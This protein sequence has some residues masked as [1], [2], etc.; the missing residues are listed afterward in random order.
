MMAQPQKKDA[1]EESVPMRIICCI[2]AVI[3]I[4]C[5]FIFGKA[6]VPVVDFGAMDLAINLLSIWLCIGGCM[7][8]YHYRHNFPPQ[9]ER[10]LKIA[11][12]CIL[13][14]LARELW[15]A[16][17]HS[18]Q[19]ECLYPLVNAL[20]ASSIVS[21][22]ELRSRKDIIATSAFGLTLMAL[23]GC[24]GRSI[25]FGGCV[26]LY[27]VLGGVLLCLC[28]RSYAM[29]L[30]GADVRVV[31]SSTR[32][33]YL[34][35]LVLSVLMLPCA[36]VAAFSFLPRA[37]SLADHIATQVRSFVTTFIYQH[38]VGVA[39]KD[40]GLA[41]ADP[42][43]KA[44]KRKPKAQSLNES[45]DKAREDEK[46]K[47]DAE[48]VRQEKAKAEK[49]KREAIQQ[50]AANDDK[51]KQDK[52]K[53][54]PEKV[55]ALPW[56][57]SLEQQKDEPKGNGTI[58]DGNPQIGP[59]GVKQ[60]IKPPLP[61]VPPPAKKNSAV[62]S[63]TGENVPPPQAKSPAAASGSGTV[64]PPDVAAPPLQEK[65]ALKNPKSKN[66]AGS[67]KTK[68]GKS[69]TASSAIPALG[70]PENPAPMPGLQK[71]DVPPPEGK[72]SSDKG[73]KSGG[74]QPAKTPQPNANAPKDGKSAPANT[75]PPPPDGQAPAAAPPASS[76]APKPP[77][78]TNAP[79]SMTGVTADSS[80][81]L[82]RPLAKSDRPLFSLACNRRVYVKLMCLDSF[83]GRA[84]H[85]TDAAETWGMPPTERGVDLKSCPFL[86]VSQALPVMELTENFEL[87]SD[88]GEFVPTAGVAKHLSLLSSVQVDR[89]GNIMADPSLKPGA[90]YTAICD[91]PSV[92]LPQMR[93]T[94][95]FAD[96]E[97][98]YLARYLILPENQSDDVVNLSDELCR[99]GVN[100]FT[101]AES[102]VAYL[103]KNYKYTDD[104][105]SGAE[106]SNLADE[107]LFRKK[108]GD[109]KAFATAFVVLCRSAGIPSRLVTGFL[110]GDPDPVSG[111]TTVKVKHAHAW[112]EIY[113]EPYG[114]VSFDPT[115]GGLL[116]ARAEQ[117]YY[118]YAEVKRDL[119]ENANTSAGQIFSKVE[120]GLQYAGYLIL[121]LAAGGAVFALYFIIRTLRDILREMSKHKKFKHPAMRFKK[122][123]MQRLMKLGITG[124]LS[125]TGRDVIAKLER[126]LETS[127]N[128]P[129]DPEELQTSVEEF[130]ETYNA[131]VFGKADDMARLRAITTSIELQLKR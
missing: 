40:R 101:Q 4:S 8:S 88:V 23:A 121:V 26:L 7:F 13:L 52:T 115:P 3:A 64:P 70:V 24:S 75:P 96:T 53:S 61:M 74:K 11:A 57:Y 89:Y 113:M 119:E 28:A 117:K 22:F 106:K 126:A 30:S 44:K 29:G 48:K 118:N 5:S 37:D 16:N 84:W 17:L 99:S 2:L 131:V 25:I 79:A 94:P 42:N 82:E 87:K 27:I 43:Q 72:T 120:L 50:A 9:V 90:K 108:K 46:A 10:G 104:A 92:S 12:I 65:A 91:M 6:P 19:F 54:E 80:V 130:F 21:C 125:D 35:A 63:G 69:E 33:H 124:D 86:E 105:L 112:A 76:P 41:L 129:E 78:S 38:R 47:E 32:G 66:Q 15:M 81:S 68:A 95:S 39:P 1:A 109:C 122:R 85:R 103:R 77:A 55:H 18:Q 93:D 83:D 67:E 127:A 123:V 128:A 20:T 58:K 102:I 100:R 110:P 34:P 31:Q 36:S 97:D 60:G 114:W 71:P 59:N 51:A 49:A 14:N 56:P 45:E 73:K 111:A 116:P 107:F 62:A 98:R